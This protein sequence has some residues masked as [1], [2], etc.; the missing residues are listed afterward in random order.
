[1]LQRQTQLDAMT[2][3]YDA[4]SKQVLLGVEDPSAKKIREVEAQ[5]AELKLRGAAADV[6]IAEATKDTKIEQINLARDAAKAEVERAV[7]EGKW[8]DRN[9]RLKFM[10]GLVGNTV[11]LAQSNNEKVGWNWLRIRPHSIKWR[12]PEIS[13]FASDLPNAVWMI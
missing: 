5:L 8:T 1:L 4:L 2:K 9:M 12:T 6:G 7:K 10:S 13:D 11:A 3:Y